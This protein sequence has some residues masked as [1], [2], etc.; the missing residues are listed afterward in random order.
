[1]KQLGFVL[2]N[3]NLPI[4]KSSHNMSIIRMPRVAQLGERGGY[5]VYI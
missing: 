5:C 2:N 1:M 3:E 4:R